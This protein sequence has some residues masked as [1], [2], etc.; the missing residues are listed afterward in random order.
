MRAFVK[1][2][3]WLRGLMDKETEEIFSR[4]WGNGY[5]VLP[6]DHIFHGVDF[7]KIPLNVH[8]G[9]TYSK[10]VTVNM[11]NMID[12]NGNYMWPELMMKDI[13]GWLIGFDTSHHTDNL[14]N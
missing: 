13:G 10:L 5:V 4:G 9:L 2:C 11:V 8:G 12:S 3:H 7:T 1:G 6:P 14:T